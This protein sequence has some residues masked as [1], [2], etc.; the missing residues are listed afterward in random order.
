VTNAILAYL[1]ARTAETVTVGAV[2]EHL[3]AAGL[4]TVRSH[5]AITLARFARHGLAARIRRG[6]YRINRFH[7]ELL[8][9][10]Q[11]AEG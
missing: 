5:A 11:G 1:A 9:M 4:P 6:V 10:R 2:T 7:P 3:A 8:S